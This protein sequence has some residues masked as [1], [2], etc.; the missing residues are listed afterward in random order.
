[1]EAT[2]S[3]KRELK[4]VWAWLTPLEHSRLKIMAAREGEFMEEL[5]RRAIIDYLD[6]Q[7]QEESRG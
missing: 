6:R 5:T 1:M 2:K 4:R 3:T 7:D